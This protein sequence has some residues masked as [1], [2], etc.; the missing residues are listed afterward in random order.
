MYKF[1]INDNITTYKLNIYKYY[2]GR[3]Y[4]YFKTSAVLLSYH[5]VILNNSRWRQSHPPISKSPRPPGWQYF[6][7]NI[8]HW[9]WS[10]HKR[11]IICSLAI[12]SN[13]K[14]AKSMTNIY[15][16]V[17]LHCMFRNAFI[18]SFYFCKSLWFSYIRSTNSSV[19][20]SLGTWEKY[21]LHQV[22]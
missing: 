22:P 12:L 15:K 17:L 7:S 5:L 3:Y 6:V 9:M 18:L 1:E 13:M 16:F 2:I 21:E 8:S 4:I 10:F 19:F 14:N 20:Y 11:A